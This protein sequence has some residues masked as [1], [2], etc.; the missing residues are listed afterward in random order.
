MNGRRLEA[1]KT[2]MT[3][4]EGARHALLI[5]CPTGGLQGVATDICRMRDE[6]E[7]RGFACCDCVGV[8]ATREAIFM[9][10]AVLR[11][12]AEEHDAVV[13]YYTGHGGRCFLADGS[14]LRPAWS[15][16]V[17][18]GHC[19]ETNFQ[20]IADFELSALVREISA[21]TPNVTVI[22]DCCHS[23]QLCRGAMRGG[24]WGYRSLGPETRSPRPL[25][26]MPPARSEVLCT[27]FQ[28]RRDPT[29]TSF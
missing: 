1:T 19:F 2:T 7:A 11:D 24:E 20:G 26:T 27:S 22:L 13:I 8:G 21:K 6:L 16:L 18:S 5:G 23:S 15:Y 10:L 29:K 14:G 9:A 4:M 12:T 25:S 17:P 28:V 3:E